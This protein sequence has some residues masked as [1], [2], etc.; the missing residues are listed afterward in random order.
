[1][2]AVID[3]QVRDLRK[4]QAVTGYRMQLRAG[5]YWG[6]RSHVADYGVPDAFDCPPELTRRLAEIPT[7]L[8]KLDDVEQERLI[9]WGYAIVDAAMRSHVD[10]ELPAP[11]GWPYEGGVGKD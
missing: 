2:L 6:V 3:N 5:T 10:E 7:R 1:V 4:R 8:K 9:N 11:V